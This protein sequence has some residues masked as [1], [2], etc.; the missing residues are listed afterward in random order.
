VDDRIVFK[1]LYGNGR[2]GRTERQRKREREIPI[3]TMERTIEMAIEAEERTMNPG[4]AEFRKI[5]MKANYGERKTL[6]KDRHR[7]LK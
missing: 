1:R 7:R 6:P 4:Q 5:L 2:K 3:T